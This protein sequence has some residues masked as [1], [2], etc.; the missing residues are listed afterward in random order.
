MQFFWR[1]QVWRTC[2]PVLVVVVQLVETSVDLYIARRFKYVGRVVVQFLY[3][4][5]SFYPGT[6]RTHSLRPVNEYT[7]FAW[8][9]ADKVKITGHS[10]ATWNYASGFNTSETHDFFYDERLRSHCILLFLRQ[11]VSFHVMIQ[12]LT[13]HI[14]N[15]FV[16][17]WV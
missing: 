7:C 16:L 10:E 17:L 1:V 5:L 13:V 11:K 15:L 6:N 3:F 8:V 14:L 4:F 9:T 2:C 12:I